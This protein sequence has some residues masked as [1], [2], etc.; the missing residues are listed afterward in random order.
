[1]E[2]ELARNSI[3]PSICII[4]RAASSYLGTAIAIITGMAKNTSDAHVSEGI[5]QG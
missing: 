4:A 3:V 5:Y 2:L 1:M